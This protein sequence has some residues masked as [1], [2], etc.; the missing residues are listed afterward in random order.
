MNLPEGRY[1]DLPEDMQVY[2]RDQHPRGP[3]IIEEMKARDGESS[4][5]ESSDDVP[6]YEEWSPKDL[7]AEAG[8]RGLSVEGNKNTLIQRL[9]QHDEETG[10]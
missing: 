3:Q 10:S 6:P 1:E 2:L 4:D 7:K 9:Y 8:A 5:E